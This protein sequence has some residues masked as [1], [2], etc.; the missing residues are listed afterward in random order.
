MTF[1]LEYTIFLQV[2]QVFLV[3]MN[4]VDKDGVSINMLRSTTINII[5]DHL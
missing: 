5:W 4:L 1:K 3:L 2:I